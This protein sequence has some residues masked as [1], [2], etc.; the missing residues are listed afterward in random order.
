[1]KIV[2]ATLADLKSILEINQQLHLDIPD[3]RWD[4]ELWAMEEIEQG[5][6]Y[7]AKDHK[8]AYGTLCLQMALEQFPETVAYIDAM[9][10][11]EDRHG[12]GI[13]KQM[14]DFAINESK[15]ADKKTLQVESFHEYSVK[16]FYIK[17]GFKLQPELGEFNGH[18]YYVFSMNI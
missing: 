7:V 1:M 11:S 15:K 4:T 18:P 10:V 8:Y 13:G 6:F 5:N 14:V 9:A 3:F 17:R 16:E 12:L 2:K